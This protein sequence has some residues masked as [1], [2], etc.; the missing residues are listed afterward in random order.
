MFKKIWVGF[1]FLTV[2][3]LMS[4]RYRVR[5]RG[6]N[7]LTPEV[8]SK[9]G[10]IL[11]LPNHPAEV[12][13]IIIILALWRFRPRPIVVEHFFYL[14]LGHYFMTLIGAL[15]LPDLNGMV[16]KW[17]QKK[18]EKLFAYVSEELK[19]GENFLIYPSG[20]LKVSGAE[21]IGGAS[22]VHNLLKE[23]PNV[24]VVLIR[25]SGLW[26]SRFSRAI[27]GTTPDFA[28]VAWEGVKIIL[29]NG[30]FLA[31][32]RDVTIEVQATPADFPYAGTRLELNQYLE[33]WYN[34]HGPEPLKLISDYFWKKQ[35]PT[36]AASE[37]TQAGEAAATV[38][39][40]IEKTVIAKVAELTKRQPQDIQRNQHLSRDLGLDSLDVAQIYV[41]LDDRYDV[42]GLIPGQLQTVEDVLKA[43]SG[44]K[45][46]FREASEGKLVKATWPL[47]Q[48]RPAVLAPQGKTIQE[49]FL[50]VC[51]RMDG[52][53]A[54]ADAIYGVM[55][56]RRLKLAA[57]TLA[58]K[59]R[60]IDGKYIGVLLPSSSAT[61]LLIFAILLAKKV[62]VM[63]NWT[64]G[65]RA[66]DHCVK[67]TDL[68]VV[69]SS[70]R[71]LNNLNNGDLGVVDDLLILLEDLREEI[72]LSHKVAALY[73]LLKDTDTLLEDLKLADIDPKDP[74]V[75]LFT[76]GTEA[77]PKGVPL[78]H[79][80]LI[81][82][83]TAALNCV[84]FQAKDVLY[85]VLPPFHSF[86]FS[87]TGL[88][89]ILAGMRAYYAPDPNDGHGMARDIAN[90]KVTLFCCAPTFMRGLFHVASLKQLE[91]LQYVVS[92][93]E[94]APQELIEFVEKLS[95]NKIFI[96]GYG[97]TECGPM[98]TITLPLRPRRGVG[99]PL[100][101]V[102]I[103]VIDAE[104]SALLP[105]GKEGEVCIRGPNVFAGYLGTQ[106]SPFITLD[107]KEWYRSG[108]RGA[109]AEDGSLVLSGRLKRFVKIG[110][111]MVSLGGLEEDLLRLAQELKWPIPTEIEGHPLAV[112]V[113]ERESEKPEIILFTTF[114]ISKED[115]N[116]ALRKSGYGSIVKISEVRKLEQIP[117]TGTGKTHYRALDE[118]LA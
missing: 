14:A 46:K 72:T 43:A 100:P 88:L 24:N 28:R 97:I 44:Q 64:V 36:I 45:E 1:L 2:K 75:V 6:V 95:G 93:A 60:N 103:C 38:S 81:S 99:V 41:F 66:L 98:V 62:P 69:L 57:L 34:V 26:G 87:V 80:N 37:K 102:E 48:S 21:I 13:P 54:C 32:R 115:V 77:L 84:D 108:D 10:G 55:T 58:G 105:Q 39:P 113:K 117:L 68:K 47:E 18:I 104:N 78:S 114:D 22:F 5:I 42:G 110:G 17:K 92:G 56:Y 109:L 111:E 15:P 53:A 25:T 49:A 20:K 85:G 16:N 19:K 8:L 65:V 89:P 74:A 86:G 91:P 94:K 12:D 35:Y 27:T 50:R 30:I 40:E 3:G 96:E 83:Q 59:L 23:S 101:G 31:P 106:K 70:R 79:T 76:S 61:Y 11:F 33:K 63:L 67:M 7:T 107:G 51:D 73:G 9:P 118:M 82:N 52:Y 90:W 116:V 71:F 112:G 4:I 29:K